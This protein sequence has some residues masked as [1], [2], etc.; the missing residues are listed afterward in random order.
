MK[1]IKQLVSTIIVFAFSMIVYGQDKLNTPA[2]FETFKDR[3]QWMK[4]NNAAGLLLDKPIDY[5]EVK[6]SYDSHSGNF[7]RPQT[8]EKINNLNFNVEG[9]VFVGNIYTWGKFDYTRAN[10]TDALFNSS[11]IDPYRDMPYMVADTNLSK[12]KNQIYDL[13]F[14]VATPKFWN[15]L[16]LGLDGSYNASSGAK[17]RDIRSENYY[18]LL[19]V[20]PGVV[21][22]VNGNHSIG[23][24]FDFQTLKEESNLSN[25]NSYVD[26]NYY[27]L[28]GLGAAI[29]GLGAGRSTNY[30]GNS[31]GGGI[32]YNYQGFFNLLLSSNY[33]YK[34]EDVKT[35][36]TSPREDA[37]VKTKLWDAKLQIFKKL[38]TS[39]HYLTLNYSNKKM[40]GIEAITQYDN[41]QNQNGYITIYKDI[42]S[43]YKFQLASADYDFTIDRE[44]EYDWKFG[45]GVRYTNQEDV[46]LTPRSEKNAENIITQFRVKKNFILSKDALQRRVLISADYSY[47]KNLSG[48]YDYNGSHPEYIVVTEFEPTDTNY[49]N[50]NFYSLGA[51][52]TY[53]QKIKEDKLANLFAKAEF[54]YTKATSFEF[55]NRNR[56]Q[57]SIGCNF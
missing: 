46:Y 30:E 12:W 13:Q 10:I 7:H 24:N 27:L 48:K 40:D 2:A 32:Q 14:K 34:V 15:K 21:Y 6:F 17:Q 53:S 20:K 4:T 55:D 39:T 18:Y 29:K 37:T 42:R 33:K 26:Q 50:S 8:G 57:I 19:Q 45:V 31:V 35:S 23:A 56:L 52:L 25:V 5:T 43:T 16:S 11:I 38:S 41:S 47:N 3:S 9:A 44:L 1:N 54:R 22:S 36:S 51:S 49:L 28:Y